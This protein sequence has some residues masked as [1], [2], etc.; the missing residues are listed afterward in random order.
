[1]NQLLLGVPIQIGGEE[2]IICRDSIG[3][4]ALNSS[5]ES[6]VFTIIEGPREDGRPAI[7]IDEDELKSMRESYPGINVYGLWQL[8]FA[9]NL[10]PLGNEVII[11]PMGPDRGLYL[12]LDSSADVD[13][14]SSI[15][16]SSEFVDNFIPEWMDY[17]L[18]NASRI[19]LDN[20]DLVLPDSPA[21]TRQELFEKQRHDQTKR[22]YMVASICGLILIATLAY[23]YGMYT[24]YNADMANYKTK[25]IQRDE[26]DTKIGELLR[27]RLDKWPENSAELGKISELLSYD[28]NMETSPDGETHVGFT[29]LH[30]FST[31]KNFPFDP[32]KKIHGITSE[33]TPHLNY[34]I[35]IDPTV[36]V[37]SDK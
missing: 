19:N 18:S 28:A 7:Y 24:V 11:F 6:E 15:L 3:S 21:Y 2:V 23:N 12:R 5:R 22:W 25:Q 16:S 4:Q 20:L 27:E 37:G 9:N 14:A 30:R 36:N 1:M 26:L 35:R 31:S 34:V 17:D 32:A 8:L 33:F 13:K 10:V 29:T